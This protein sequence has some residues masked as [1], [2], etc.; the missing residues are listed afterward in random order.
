MS[1][2]RRGGGDNQSITY[3]YMDEELPQKYTR[4]QRDQEEFTTFINKVVTF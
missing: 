3:D 4:F 1:T 2:M